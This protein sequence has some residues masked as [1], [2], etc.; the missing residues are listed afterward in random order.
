M[1]KEITVG[2]K[3]TCDICG[4]PLNGQATYWRETGL[5]TC[6]VSC[7]KTLRSKRKWQTRGRRSVQC[8]ESAED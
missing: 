1:K 6:L 4:E 7:E 2:T 3:Y 8:G 5:T